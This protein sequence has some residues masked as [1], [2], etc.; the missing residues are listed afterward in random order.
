MWRHNSATVPW[1]SCT[2][3]HRPADK[4]LS[5]GWPVLAKG[6]VILLEQEGVASLGGAASKPSPARLPLSP[7]RLSG[8]HFLFPPGFWWGCR[9]AALSGQLQTIKPLSGSLQSAH[10]Q[11][12]IPWLALQS[13]GPFCLGIVLFSV[14]RAPRELASSALCMN[15]QVAHSVFTGYISQALA[16]LCLVCLTTCLFHLTKYPR[17]LSLSVLTGLPHS[18]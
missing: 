15:V 3:P 13:S 7:G 17:N 2:D 5:H 1:Q 10:L 4:G 8:G 18:L 11:Q 16:L 12:G 6:L 14:S 9:S